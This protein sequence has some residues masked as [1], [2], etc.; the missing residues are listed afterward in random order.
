MSLDR[1]R[2]HTQRFG[3]RQ[4]FSI[5][6]WSDFMET[7]WG[8]GCQFYVTPVAP[9]KVCCVLMSRDPHLRIA[10]ALPLFPELARRLA[11]TAGSSSERGAATGKRLLHRVTRGNIALVGDAAG[12]ADPITGQGLRLAFLQAEALAAALERGD[13]DYY[14]QAHRSMMRQPSIM[15]DLMHTLDRW[16]RLRQR[17]IPALAARP[18]LFGNLLALHV[19]E[20]SLSRMAAT[21]TALCWGVIAQ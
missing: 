21:A 8:N 19:G 20:G 2:C 6:P 5:A 12:C 3:F 18:D 7:H 13:L 15:G 1:W 4:H 16:P 9:G 10:G 11:A 17:A 14:E